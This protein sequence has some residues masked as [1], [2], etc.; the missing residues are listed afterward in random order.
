MGVLVAVA[1]GGVVGVIDGVGVTSVAQFKCFGVPLS[2]LGAVVHGGVIVQ[3]LGMP[4]SNPQEIT[5]VLVIHAVSPSAITPRRSMVP[6]VDASPA[7]HEK[8]FELAESIKRLRGSISW[9]TSPLLSRAV[10]EFPG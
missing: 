1:F 7:G 2:A 4:A 8:P 6:N 9:R 5:P 3:L 10:D